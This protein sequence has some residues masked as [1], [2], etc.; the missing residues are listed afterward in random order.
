MKQNKCF[1]ILILLFVTFALVSSAYTLSNPRLTHGGTGSAFSGDITDTSFDSEMCRQGQDFIVQVAPFGCEPAVVRSDLL[2][3]QDVPVFCK[4][5]AIKINP[6]IDITSIDSINIRGE[7]PREVKSVGFTPA[8]SALGENRKLNNLQWDEIGYATIVLKRN[9][10]ESS[11]P[12]LVTGNLSAK[13][14]YDLRN[15]FG[16]RKHTFYLPVLND[17]EFD[18]LMGQYAFFNKMG[19]LRAE[20]VTKDSA[21][22]A[23]YSGR[24]EAPFGKSRAGEI[25]RQ[26]IG[27]YNLQLGQDTGKIYLP[28]FDCFSAVQFKLDDIEFQ[29]T[30]V[31][32]NINS[33][34]Y[35]VK[36]KERFLDNKCYVRNIE[37][38][39]LN[40]I[41]TLTCDEDKKTETF[42]LILSPKIVLKIDGEEREY[43]VGDY[44]FET[45]EGEH[46]YL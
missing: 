1:L 12:D 3:E 7:Y 43:A 29:D 28:G 22:I 10:N 23:I 24:Y 30:R 25:S 19:Y 37:K 33:R 15:A 34:I 21:S 16:L 9:P 39:G 44:L 38:S 36:E 5:Q 45:N 4:L 26:R 14:T 17:N 40:Q 32:L 2:E 35:E 31:R 18:S 20:D 11:M 41:V 46:A 27:K 42:D 8:Y 13:I 6:F